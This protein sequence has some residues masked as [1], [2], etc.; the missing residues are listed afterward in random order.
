MTYDD[1]IKEVPNSGC[2][3]VIVAHKGA[4]GMQA[5]RAAKILLHRV[6]IIWFSDDGGFVEESYRIGCAYFSPDTVNEKILST[7]LGRCK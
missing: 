7:A 3:S 2:N 1:F 5:A 6:P 4:T